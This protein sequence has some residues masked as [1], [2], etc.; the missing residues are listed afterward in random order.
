MEHAT[1]EHQEVKDATAKVLQA[2]SLEGAIEVIMRRTLI[3]EE[4]RDMHAKVLAC[5][6]ELTRLS[7][8]IEARR[9]EVTASVQEG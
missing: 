7:R 2:E 4:R 3:D 9:A 5:G 6:M 8:R 1:T